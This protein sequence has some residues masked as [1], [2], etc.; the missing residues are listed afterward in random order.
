MPTTLK[1]TFGDHHRIPASSEMSGVFELFCEEVAGFD[2]ARNV[3]NLGDAQLMCFTDVIFLEIDVF[4]ALVCDRGRPIYTGFIIIVNCDAF[5]CVVHVEI[6][7][8]VENV[9][10][11]GDTFICCDYFGFTTAELP[12]CVLEACLISIKQPSRPPLL[13]RSTQPSNFDAMWL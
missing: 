13:T 9:F 3:S 7:C 4:G 12:I 2:D 11:L 10:E 8:S 5:V 1:I 6:L